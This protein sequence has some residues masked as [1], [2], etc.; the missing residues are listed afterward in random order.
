MKTIE[1]KENESKYLMNGRKYSEYES[2]KS[3]THEL[4]NDRLF[5]IQH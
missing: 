2:I 4:H 1:S 3:D 5:L